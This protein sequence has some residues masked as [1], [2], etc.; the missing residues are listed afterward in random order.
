MVFFVGC[1]FFSKGNWLGELENTSVRYG[2]WICSTFKTGSRG[3]LQYLLSLQLRPRREPRR[4][5]GEGKKEPAR[6]F[7]RNHK[8]S[9][10]PIPKKKPCRLRLNKPSEFQG[11]RKWLGLKSETFS[12]KAGKALVS[13]FSRTSEVCARGRGTGRDTSWTCPGLRW[14]IRSD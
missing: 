4:W 6:K 11:I 2:K 13:E 10:V 1:S 9:Q 8:I 14:L 5:I 12:G 3:G 7:P